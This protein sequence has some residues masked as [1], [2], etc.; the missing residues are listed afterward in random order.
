MLRLSP[1][2]VSGTIT[3]LDSSLRRL[4]LELAVQGSEIAWPVLD[5]PQALISRPQP[6]HAWCREQ[7]RTLARLAEEDSSYGYYWLKYPPI[8]RQSLEKLA[9]YY[10]ESV[11]QFVWWFL[12]VRCVEATSRWSAWSWI[13]ADIGDSW[14]EEHREP[15]FV[16]LV[17]PA[18]VEAIWR[19]LWDPKLEQYFSLSERLRTSPITLSEDERQLVLEC[20]PDCPVCRESAETDV[21]Q[22]WELMH[23]DTKEAYFGTRFRRQLLAAC[24]GED[25]VR[26]LQW[27]IDYY[28][29]KA[30][31]IGEDGKRKDY[32]WID[33]AVFGDELEWY[34]TT[35]S[36]M[37]EGCC[38]GMCQWVEHR[39]RRWRAKLAR[40]EEGATGAP[41]QNE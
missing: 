20:T 34:L 28:S 17:S 2:V 12:R 40:S 8:L 19:A 15:S 4:F 31:E 7:A 26:F 37:P 16:K 14:I 3:C 30:L 36:P 38:L 27:A 11:A 13:G 6:F 24:Q 5:F 21:P 41:M 25:Y 10:D 23:S 35:G 33:A 29:Q 22:L 32:S 9:S 39:A 1:P 18:V